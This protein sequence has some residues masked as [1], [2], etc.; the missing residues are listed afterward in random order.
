MAL[1]CTAGRWKVLESCGNHALKP[2]ISMVPDRSGWKRTSVL[3]QLSKN[4]VSFLATSSKRTATSDRTMV[5]A[6]I[7]PR[8]DHRIPNS[9]T[10]REYVWHIVVISPC[11][12]VSSHKVAEPFISLLQR[13]LAA[14]SFQDFNMVHTCS[15]QLSSSE[16]CLAESLLARNGES[17]SQLSNSED[18]LAESP[19]P[20]FC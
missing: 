10:R 13:S 3:I 17:R 20:G 12:H 18:Y 16:D 19:A 7:I 6:R 11:S 1:G 14:H 15:Y 5:A 9:M 2:L 4:V 8:F